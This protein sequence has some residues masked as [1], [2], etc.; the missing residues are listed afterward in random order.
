MVKRSYFILFLII[1]CFLASGILCGCT[2][3]EEYFVPPKADTSIIGIEHHN[4]SPFEAAETVISQA[5]NEVSERMQGCSISTFAQS[6]NMLDDLQNGVLDESLLK[7]YAQDIIEVA[8]LTNGTIDIRYCEADFNDDKLMDKL[9]IISSSLHSGSRGDQ[10]SI[11]LNDGGNYTEITDV[12]W[13]LRLLKQDKNRTP[14]G[15]IHILKSKTNGFYDIEIIAEDNQITLKYSG[16]KYVQTGSVEEKLEAPYANEKEI[17][18]QKDAR[19]Q[20]Q[21][22]YYDVNEDG[23][24]E[25][26]IKTDRELYVFLCKENDLEIVYS[27]TYS[28]L[29]ENGMI[30]YYRPGGAPKHDNYIFYEFEQNEYKE[31]VSLSRYDWDENGIYEEQDKYYLND[32]QVTMEEWNRCLQLYKEWEENVPIRTETYSN[33]GITIQ[34]PQLEE[35]ED[36]KKEEK[37]NELIKSHIIDSNLK[38]AEELPDTDKL[39]LNMD[40]KIT[41]NSPEVLS[42]L[43]KGYSEL[44]SHSE[45]YY[46]GC[47]V[48][49]LTIDLIHAEEM[50]LTDFVAIDNELVRRIKESVKVVGGAPQEWEIRQ[51][52]LMDAVQQQEEEYMIQGLQEGWSYYTFCITPKSVILSIAIPHSEGDYALIEVDYFNGKSRKI[53][54]NSVETDGKNVELQDFA[55]YPS[56]IS[57]RNESNLNQYIWS[58]RNIN[59]TFPQIYFSNN[60]MQYDSEVEKNINK[61]LFEQSLM[62]DVSFL[63]GRDMRGLVE[64]NMDYVITKANE[65]VF[66][67]QYQGQLYSVN[68]GNNICSGITIDIR[69]GERIDLSEVITLDNTLIEKIRNGQIEY[70]DSAGYEEEFIIE[71]VEEFLTNYQEG[72]LDTYSCYFLEDGMVNLIIQ[73]SHGNSNYII[74]KIPID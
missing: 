51:E 66:S 64:Y 31:K 29:M 28:V 61:A 21:V 24:D 41:M 20:A 19:E 73:M 46:Y 32:S 62:N 18:E 56:T 10:F 53:M 33:E 4:T 16:E 42:I 26:I 70:I 14:N 68:H 39:I 6:K 8:R 58:E 59:I 36:E 60:Y 1:E 27:G 52:D 38:V 2:K 23:N 11:L 9:V 63:V 74:V 30:K 69:T 35:L 50:Q 22:S 48:A 47:E 13:H 5:D 34:Y 43:Y 44:Q 7:Y 72:L 65:Y 17:T 25:L 45:T 12:F 67:I 40:Y 54:I 57:E 15:A 55:I 71:L 49:T 37:I 3:K